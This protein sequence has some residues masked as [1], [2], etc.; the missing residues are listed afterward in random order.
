MICKS[1]YRRKHQLIFSLY[2]EVLTL[3]LSGVTHST[4]QL[5]WPRAARNP[6]APNPHKAFKRKIGETMS[7]KIFVVVLL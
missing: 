4:P 7:S 6:H 1:I 5:F 3:M 2:N